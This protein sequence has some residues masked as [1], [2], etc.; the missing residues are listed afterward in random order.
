MQFLSNK[1]NIIIKLILFFV[2]IFTLTSCQS[3]DKT[4]SYFGIDDNISYTCEYNESNNETKIRWK[5]YIQNN[6]IF[7]INK[8]YVTFSIYDNETNLGE[9]ELK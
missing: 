7:D 8:F 4:E 5:S 6:T 3:S 1:R 9:K 2:F